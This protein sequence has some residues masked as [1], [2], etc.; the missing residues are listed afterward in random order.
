MKKILILLI[1]LL[2]GCTKNTYTTIS[3]S[4][5]KKMNIID[6]RLNSDY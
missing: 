3:Q 6:E 1:L 5:A 2:V 4:E